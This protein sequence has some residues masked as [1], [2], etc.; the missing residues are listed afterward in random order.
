[1]AT[2][3]IYIV[4]VLPESFPVEKRL[5]LRRQ[6]KMANAALTAD[7]QHHKARQFLHTLAI[8]LEPLKQL[9]PTLHVDTGKRNWRLVFCAIHIF[10]ANMGDSYAVVSMILFL[11]TRYNYTP[12]EVRQ[13]V[14]PCHPLHAQC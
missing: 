3:W 14:S 2:G 5:E 11:T 9:K 13:S 7:P 8:P 1:M 10:L 6:R 4:S 12:A